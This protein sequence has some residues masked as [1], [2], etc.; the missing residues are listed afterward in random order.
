MLCTRLAGDIGGGCVGGWAGTIDHASALSSAAAPLTRAGFGL[1]P[2]DERA[3]PRP[4]A[5]NAGWRPPAPE[6]C[7]ASAAAAL[8]A[9]SPTLV[10]L[11]SRLVTE[12]RFSNL[13]R[14]AVD[15]AR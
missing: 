3:P 7:E 13:R 9:G 5:A 8:A 15:M 11:P 10:T 1:I 2:D 12:M 14:K 4:T 6:S